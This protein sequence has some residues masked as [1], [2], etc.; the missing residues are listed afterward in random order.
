MQRG[1][2]LALLLCLCFGAMGA[3]RVTVKVDSTE[4]ATL[5]N[6]MS[7]IGQIPGLHCV[8]DAIY[9]DG[10]GEAEVFMDERKL[11]E[12][13]ELWHTL[14]SRVADIQIIKTPGAA[15]DKT[16]QAVV[17]IHLK[18]PTDDGLSLDEN[19]ALDYT[20][21]AALSNKLTLGWKRGRLNTEAFAG[22]E[23][24]R[25]T[26]REEDYTVTY[27]GR[28]PVSG[29]K[30]V[31]SIYNHTQKLTLKINAGY[32]FTPLHHLE[33]AY[34]FHRVPR[35]TDEVEGVEHY[36][37]LPIGGT[38]DFDHPVSSRINAGHVNRSPRTHHEANMEYRGYV[39]R[40]TLSAGINANFIN[41]Y[42]N[43][44]PYN[45]FPTFHQERETITR[46]FLKANRPLGKG[47][48]EAGVEFNT[49][50]MEVTD[51]ILDPNSPTAPYAKEH[52][53][54]SDQTLATFVSLSQQFGIWSLSGGLRYEGDFFSYKPYKDDGVMWFL[55][56][57]MPLYGKRIDPE[58]YIF[59]RLWR[60][61]KFTQSHHNVYPNISL[62][63]RLGKSN[64]SLSYTRSYQ[65]AYL[66]FSQI[67]LKDLSNE[68]LLSK[69]MDDEKIS[70]T[71][72]SYGWNWI[73][74]S[75]TH[76]WH[77]TPVFSSSDKYNGND[78]HGLTLSV[79]AAPT[80]G[81]WS[82]SLTAVLYKQWLHMECANPK[83]LR[84]PLLSLSWTNS[85]RLPKDWLVFLN[86][87]WHSRGSKYDLY[88]HS[89]NLNM[90]VAVQKL[91][92]HKQ[93][94]VTLQMS[95]IFRRSY[96]DVTFFNIDK[97][98]S[99]GHAIRK[100]RTLTLSVNYHF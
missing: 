48:L 22:W 91:F 34:K 44:Y 39:R 16:V 52:V 96:E 19:L 6:V 87:N 3:D 36:D 67:T 73:N 99:T 2:F 75:L 78:Y 93:L 72:L 30:N 58:K 92:L 89:T 63:V 50:G 15:Y 61:R 51:E 68:K 20:D 25:S 53:Y 70:T 37:Y 10:R 4:L 86:A 47:S 69:I 49:D 26:S 60:D 80:I 35:K 65:K 59:A 9:V 42:S 71:V 17:I 62:G 18:A 55:D 64:L 1:L 43:G 84:T 94:S 82:P 98:S 66:A 95:N 21:R 85:L 11:S 24:Q 12:I 56:R 28:S 57:L 5:D 41:S 83:N 79:A 8:D 100:P 46:S 97:T 7:I 40:W 74:T 38:I 29:S 27:S 54:N 77:T 88:Y 90:D 32:D 76:E 13:T 81:P 23:Q 33:V 31:S 14:A 45:N